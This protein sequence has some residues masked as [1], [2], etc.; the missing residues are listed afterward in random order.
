VLLVTA[1]GSISGGV[2]NNGIF[3][4]THEHYRFSAGENL[5]LALCV[6]L[7][8]ALVAR[9]AGRIGALLVAVPSRRL[10][11]LSFALWSAAALWPV[12]VPGRGAI[13]TCTL[14]GS[15]VGGL[16]WPVVESYLGGGRHGPELRRALGGFNL[17]WTF[18]SA[19]PLVILEPLTRLH[20][21][22]PLVLCALTN[23][24]A[25]IA[26]VLLLPARPP[27]SHPDHAESAV[28]AEYPALLAATRWLLP[29]A[30]VLSSTLAPVLPF[31]LAALGTPVPA[32]L[33]AAT[34]MLARF[35]TL[36]GMTAIPQWHGRWGALVA[37]AGALMLGVALALLG[38]SLLAMVL[39][40]ALFGVGMG[41]TYFCS[42]YYSL[43]VG[44]AAVEA[45]GDFE[46]LIGVGYVVGPLVGMAGRALPLGAQ[47]GTGT[48][49][50]AWLVSLG[51]IG[52]AARPYLV[53]RRARR[54]S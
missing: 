1:L 8:Y 46:A 16:V 27:R 19:A 29:L 10:L 50:L 30:Y 2:F 44:H 43:A 54:R 26:L 36:G 45:G 7:A 24:G 53:A 37:G 6:G 22:G 12:L 21:L 51:G 41:I 25:I 11:A 28:G 39:G 4:L 18:A 40:L 34:W 33:V 48:V 31:R 9:S 13:W 15:A 23:L 35:A 47:A 5:G 3:F 20:P 52:L 32:A 38:Q 14:V 49:A 17:T 42:I